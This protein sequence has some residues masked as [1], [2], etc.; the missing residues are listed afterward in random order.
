MKT[1]Q[2]PAITSQKAL[3]IKHQLRLR[4]S[5]LKQWAADNGYPMHLVSNV[6]RGVNKATFGRGREVAEKLCALQ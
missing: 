6:M 4:G 3:D 2:D 1:T 5:T